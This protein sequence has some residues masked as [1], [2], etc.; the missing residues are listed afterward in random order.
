ML[1]DIPTLLKEKKAA[2]KALQDEMQILEQAMRMFPND[3]QP[4]LM[5]PAPSTIN[6]AQLRAQRTQKEALSY[7]ADQNKGYVK[8]NDAKVLL[9]KAGFCK[10]APKYIYGHLYTL[11]KDDDRYEQMGDGI[12]RMLAAASAH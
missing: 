4:A 8:V 5:D 2:I 12:F 1:Y 6:M 9:Q 7:I 10:G 11:L 3:A